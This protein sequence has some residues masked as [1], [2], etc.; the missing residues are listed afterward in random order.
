MVVGRLLVCACIH[1]VVGCP[2]LCACP[3]CD[4]RLLPV[5]TDLCCVICLD[6]RGGSC[7]APE[8]PAAKQ[9]DSRCGHRLQLG[10]CQLR[11]LNMS[12]GIDH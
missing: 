7:A 11:L 4:I 8:A 6:I 3:V 5:T 12:T 2:L 1:C 10:A 9:A